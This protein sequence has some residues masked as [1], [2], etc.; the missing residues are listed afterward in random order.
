MRKI[1]LPTPTCGRKVCLRCRQEKPLTEFTK[2]KA[3]SDG[4]DAYCKTCEREKRKALR[5]SGYYKEYAEKNRAK[6]NAQARKYYHADPEKFRARRR[7]YGASERGKKVVAEYNH[8]HWM[9]TRDDPE[10]KEKRRAR[11]KQY[12]LEHQEEH[13]LDSARQR[14]KFP[15]ETK[16]KSIVNHAI[17]DGKLARQPCEICGVEP[18]QAHHDDYNYPLEVRWLCQTCH[19]RWHRDNEPIRK[20]KENL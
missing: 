16:A 8:K 7:A 9:E 18:A 6:I 17:R 11:A 4:L 1:E 10:W 3:R 19:A 20:R 12:R 13:R 14:E 2:N 15:D 5:E